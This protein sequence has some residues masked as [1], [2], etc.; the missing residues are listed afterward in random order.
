MID[1]EVIEEPAAAAAALDG[2]RA[3]LL[4]ELGRARVGHRAGRAASARAARRSTT[5]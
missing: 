4:A 5:T 3:A 2:I 1:V